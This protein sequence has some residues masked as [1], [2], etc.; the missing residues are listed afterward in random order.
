M[1]ERAHT[2]A[3]DNNHFLWSQV[4][5]TVAMARFSERLASAKRTP[6]PHPSLARFLRR[7][8]SAIEHS[9]PTFMLGMTI[10]AMALFF[11]RAIET[12]L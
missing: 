11:A 7:E 8:R 2:S 12:V 1:K 5:Y 3:V 4:R 9:W 10:I 6:K